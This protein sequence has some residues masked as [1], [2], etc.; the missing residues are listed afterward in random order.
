MVITYIYLQVKNFELSIILRI[1]N[2]AVYVLIQY[3]EFKSRRVL[4]PNPLQAV[5]TC[6]IMLPLFMHLKNVYVHLN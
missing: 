3:C 1:I 4:I 2:Y 6:F 5:G